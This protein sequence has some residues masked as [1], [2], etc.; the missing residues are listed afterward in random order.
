MRLA[1]FTALLLPAFTAQAA[2]YKTL[3]FETTNGTEAIDLSSLVLTVKDGSLVATNTTGTETFTLTS[4]SKMYF[5]TQDATGISSVDIE[6]TAAP[7][8]AYN[9]GGQLAGSFTS[10]QEAK[11]SLRPG[12]YVIRQNG[13][14][15]K[16]TVK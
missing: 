3:V 13:K 15:Y 16:L 5:S 1:F 2:D 9:T 14:S 6:A 8:E 7:L 12:I 4:L 10:F 11:T